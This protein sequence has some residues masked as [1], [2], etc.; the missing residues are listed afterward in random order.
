MRKPEFQFYGGKDGP[1]VF[2]QG[3]A[4]HNEEGGYIQSKHD[5][6]VFIKHTS[7]NE[8]IWIYARVDDFKC[9]ATS[10]QLLI[11]YKKHLEKKYTKV[12]LVEGNDYLGIHEEKLEEGSIFT[13]PKD[14]SKLFDIYLP[15]GPTITSQ[16]FQERPTTMQK[17]YLDSIDEDSPEVDNTLYRSC[18]GLLQQQLPVRPD[19]A[20]TI[21]KLATR[22]SKA[23]SRDMEALLHLV[24]YL[25]YTRARGLFLRSTDKN[26][27]DFRIKLIAYADAAGS[28]NQDSKSQYAVTYNL[29]PVIEGD[30]KLAEDSFSSKSGNINT[31][32]IVAPTIDLAQ[33]ESEI[34]ALVE[35]T[36]DVI[37]F[38]NLLDDL[39]Q[40]QWAATPV[41]N[42]SQ[43][44]ILL[45][46]KLTGKRTRV[47][48]CLKNINWCLEQVKESIVEYLY[49]NTEKLPADA[50]TKIFNG[51]DQ[52]N[53]TNMLSGPKM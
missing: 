24:N 11:D 28:N 47:R 6:C 8:Y 29:I 33:A 4:K 50:A 1:L 9:F 7:E 41:Y 31:R 40:S 27:R 14:L 25:W 32:S 19:T 37:Y 2:F 51:K 26:Q 12:K 48:Y 53:K 38:R 39:H 35:A 42:D 18:L 15:N 36:K 5:L 10:N 17:S 46:S 13:K 34:G 22:S 20:F 49:M 52:E 45:S 30:T 23:N 3:F 21:S 43:P 44:A 16:S